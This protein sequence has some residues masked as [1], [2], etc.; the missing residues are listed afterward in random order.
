MGL[1]THQIT[2]RIRHFP[3]DPGVIAA[4]LDRL[5]LEKKQILQEASVIG[6]NFLYVILEHITDLKEYLQIVSAD[7]SGLT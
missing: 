6:R 4:R 7:W 1:E 5:D 3:N 2:Q